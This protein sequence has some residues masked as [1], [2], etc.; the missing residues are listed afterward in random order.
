MSAQLELI[1]GGARSGKSR[2]AEQRTCDS[3][4]KKIYIATATGDDEEMEA[5]IE[6]HRQRRQANSGDQPWILIE[7]PVQLANALQTHNN[8]KAC[9]LVDCLTLWVSNCLHANCWEQERRALLSILPALSGRIIFVSNEV[10]WGIVPLG[11]LSRQ[12]VDATGLLHQELASHCQRVTLITAGIPMD[13]KSN[14]TLPIQL[15]HLKD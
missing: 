5:R 12:F 9:L 6:H 13:L 8:S 4:L 10:G 1:L 3:G 7:E 2:L 11:E 15:E 14:S